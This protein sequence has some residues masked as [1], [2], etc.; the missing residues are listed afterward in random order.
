MWGFLNPVSVVTFLRWCSGSDSFP[1]LKGGA[2]VV[3]EQATANI[4][5]V[6][7]MAS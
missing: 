3:M 4:I 6:E 1:E 2:A 5:L 7:P